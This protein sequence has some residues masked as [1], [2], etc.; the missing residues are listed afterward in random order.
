MHIIHLPFYACFRLRFPDV[1]TNPGP[2]FPVPAVCRIRNSNVRGLSRDLSDLTMTSSQFDILLCPKTMVSVMCHVAE[3]LV[4]GLD[5]MS[6]CH[7]H[8]LTLSGSMLKKSVDLVI[9][10]VT[11]GSKMP[12][13]KHLCSVS[14]AASQRLG[15]LRKS[16]RVFHD[17]LLLVRCFRGFVRPVLDF[18]SAMFILGY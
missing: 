12:R 17:R 15:I 10:C 14:R 13:E 16:L 5:T 6:C 3:L 4:P 18:C 11:F 1:E 9:F 8:T 2:R 7:L